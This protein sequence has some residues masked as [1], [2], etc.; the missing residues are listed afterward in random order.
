[1]AGNLLTAGNTYTYS[2]SKDQGVEIESLLAAGCCQS[3]VLEAI[4]Q[5]HWWYQGGRWAI[6]FRSLRQYPTHSDSRYR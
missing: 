3:L 5:W 1:M 2:Y 6:C 4:R